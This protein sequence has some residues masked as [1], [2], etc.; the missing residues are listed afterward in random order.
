MVDRRS[1]GT[2]LQHWL[3]YWVGNTRTLPSQLK[4]VRENPRV[5]PVTPLYKFTSSLVHACITIASSRARS[6]ASCDSRCAL[7]RA[8]TSSSRAIPIT[9]A[10]RKRARM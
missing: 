4:T 10:T 7:Y 1:D 2:E 3:L 5:R 9:C 6:I 8:T